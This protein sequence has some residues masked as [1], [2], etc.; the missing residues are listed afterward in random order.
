MCQK[1]PSGP[2]EIFLTKI[3]EEFEFVD[4]K[5]VGNEYNEDILGKKL[6]GLLNALK[7]LNLKTFQ[8]LFF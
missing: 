6:L 7:C 3:N 5:N 1:M 4:L 2:I 8:G